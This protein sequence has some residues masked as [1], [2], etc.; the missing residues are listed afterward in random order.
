MLPITVHVKPAYCLQSL[1]HSLLL[2]GSSFSGPTFSAHQTDIIYFPPV[3][4]HCWL[5]DRK[6]IRPVNNWML[7]CWW[8]W[9]DWS[10]ARLIAPVVTNHFHHP[11]LQWT[12]ANPGSPGKWPLK[13]R[14]TDIFM[15]CVEYGVWYFLSLRCSD[16][17]GWVTQRVSGS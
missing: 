17:V 11:L 4:W 6:G 13:W 15:S 10:F 2:N 16:T 7:V 14:E 5:G 1:D 3:L 8:W 12:P 9:L